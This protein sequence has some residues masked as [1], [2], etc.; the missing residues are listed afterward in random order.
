MKILQG[1]T[2]TPRFPV[3]KDT[4]TFAHTHIIINLLVNTHSIKGN[5]PPSP[6]TQ[7][8]KA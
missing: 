6:D 7:H 3:L 2:E 8:R 4:K 5:A 1:S